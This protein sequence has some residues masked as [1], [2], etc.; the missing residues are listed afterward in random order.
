MTGQ[1]IEELKQYMHA[2]FKYDGPYTL[3]S[4]R[5]SNYYYDGKGATE[6][7][8]AAWL[9][10]KALLNIV[11]DAGAEAVGGLELG[12]VPIA[13]ATGIAAHVSRG[14]PLPTFVV[15]KSAK[16]HGTGLNVS[17]ANMPDGSR[18]L[19]PGRRVAIVD[20]VITTG[21]SIQQAIDE[22]QRL[23]CVVAVVVALV[24]RHE[25][26]EHARRLYSQGFPVR[27][28]F[29]TDEQGNLFVDQDFA[30]RAEAAAAPAV[31]RR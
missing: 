14:I 29:Y 21:G 28:L 23:G 25:A 3:A 30:G 1:E 18:L 17:E 12:A 7:G 16:T 22:V 27:R 9:I 24:E 20:D 4:G 2:C 26:A 10:G 6:Y 31:P 15:R 11:L 8:P 5:Q 13:D 19:S